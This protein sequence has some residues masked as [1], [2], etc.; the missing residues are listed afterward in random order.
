MAAFVMQAAPFEDRVRIFT[1]NLTTADNQGDAIPSDFAGFSD[2]SIQVAGSLGGG[3]L[4]WQGSNQFN[5]TDWATLNNATGE[6]ANWSAPGIKQ[7]LEGVV[8]GRPIL[9]GSSGAT[10]TVIA[11]CRKPAR[12]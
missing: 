11:M 6:P 12:G 2:R 1:W 8:F 10:C 7:I 4:L 3:A 5:P 9:T